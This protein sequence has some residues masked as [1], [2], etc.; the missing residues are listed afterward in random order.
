[1]LLSSACQI[2]LSLETEDVLCNRE[3]EDTPITMSTLQSNDKANTLGQ[4]YLQYNQWFEQTLF[5]LNPGKQL[6]ANK[7]LGKNK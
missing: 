5:F 2:L 3:E 7:Q 6:Q 4:T 1:M